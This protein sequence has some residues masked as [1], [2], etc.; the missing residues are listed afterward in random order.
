MKNILY[1]VSLLFVLPFVSCEKQEILFPNEEIAKGLLENH[2]DSLSVWLE[3]QIDPTFLSDSLKAEYGWWIVLLHRQQQRSLMNDSLIQHTL[4]YYKENG[5]PRLPFAYVLAGLQ[6]NW[7]GDKSEEEIEYIRKG[8]Q[9][10]ESLHD[11]ASFVKIGSVLS[12]S[13]FLRNELCQAVNISKKVI[14]LTKEGSS[15]RMM[16]CYTVGCNYG[17]MGGM[18]S[19]RLYMEE[20]VRIAGEL[21]HGMEFYIV[22]NYLDCLNAIWHNEEVQ[23][24]LDDFYRRF[25]LKNENDYPVKEYAYA[26]LWLNQGKMD[27][28]QACLNRLD[29]YEKILIGRSFQNKYKVPI[30]YLTELL[31]TVYKVKSGQPFN[32]IN[33]YKTSEIVGN[34]EA[35]Q[36]KIEKELTLNRSRLERDNLLLKIKEE[37]DRLLILY[38][39]LAAGLVVAVLVYL[40]QRKLLKK[41]RYVQ[42]AKEQI[43]L[44][45]IALSENEQQIRQN[46]ETIQ[47]LSTRLDGKDHLSGQLREQQEEIELIR[48]ENHAL[49]N[50]KHRLQQE[51]E[52]F[53]QTIPEKNVEMEAYERISEQNTLFVTCTKQLSVQLIE[54]NDY[55]KRLQEGEFKH[56]SDIDWQTVYKTLD[57]LFNHYTR[58]LRKNYPGLT[59]E[60]IQCCCL[61]KLQ[62]ST[63]AIAHLY[64]IAPSSVTK[65]KQRI[66]ERINQTKNG[67]IGKEQP[68]DVYLWGY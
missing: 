45:R 59:E 19:M 4:R 1:I 11:T 13:Y 23:G 15:E 17:Q 32:M 61:I 63:S 62:L 64:G 29:Q 42:Q 3:E 9:I 46:E 56:L 53:A 10:A 51:M 7:A 5:S 33:M 20:A 38:I 18:D 66:K 22:R 37:Q 60:D 25:P 58:R 35:N 65:R 26:C 39:L 48:Q 16:E 67:L 44:H 14:P 43:R 28:V 31:H 68:V 49:L 27:S 41:E 47:V 57:R 54:Q 2:P 30:F 52:R 8:W 40:Y 21:N 24:L 36:M 50:E 34:W 55:L 6:K 12:Y